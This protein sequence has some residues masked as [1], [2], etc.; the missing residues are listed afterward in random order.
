LKEGAAARRVS[1]WDRRMR[2]KVDAAERREAPA[3]RHGKVHLG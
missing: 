2:F 1:N 3:D